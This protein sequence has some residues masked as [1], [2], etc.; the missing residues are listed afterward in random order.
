MDNLRVAILE[1]LIKWRVLTYNQMYLL[2]L[3]ENT[4]KERRELF[5]IIQELIKYE[6]IQQTQ[7]K[8]EQIALSITKSGLNTFY[9]TSDND[10]LKIVGGEVVSNKYSFDDISLDSK[11][12][13]HNIHLNYF[14]MDLLSILLKSDNAGKNNFK[15]NP[16]YIDEKDFASMYKQ[17][18]FRPDGVIKYK[19]DN[20]DHYFF[21]EMDMS[22]E[23]KK[24]LLDKWMKYEQLSKEFKQVF[25][26]NTNIKILFIT[27]TEERRMISKVA[28]A[29][30][31]AEIADTQIDIFVDTHMN[32]MKKLKTTALLSHQSLIDYNRY[33]IFKKSFARNDIENVRFGYQTHNIQGFGRCIIVDYRFGHISI[34]GLA[35]K[36]E[37]I[38]GLKLIV[39]IDNNDSMAEEFLTNSENTNKFRYSIF[40]IKKRDISSVEPLS[41][42]LFTYNKYG[43][44][45]LDRNYKGNDS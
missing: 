38:D 28:L 30:Y 21:L 36:I 24:N 3:S 43:K 10:I 26:E 25:G 33:Q 39:I 8:S 31:F 37:R 1:T 42:K 20:I 27:N 34:L 45:K 44:V 32:L 16:E 4:T 35:K 12:M 19:I 23:S 2:I 41:T 7:Y 6:Y 13:N 40:F 29:E 11:I 17:F 15:F 9:K 18:G 5:D 22:T 14:A